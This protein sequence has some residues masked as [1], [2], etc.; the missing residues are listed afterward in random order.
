MA[1]TKTDGT[2]KDAFNDVKEGTQVTIT[3]GENDKVAAIQVGIAIKVKGKTVNGALAS[4]KDGTLTIKVREKKGEEPKAQDFKVADD[5]KVTVIDG[6][7]QEREYCQGC[8]QG[9]QRGDAGHHHDWRERQN[10]RHPG[11]QRTERR[12]NKKRHCF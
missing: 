12:N 3:L 7:Q 4:Y 11:R 5:T 2:A 10:C 6:K 1:A 8:L 9:R